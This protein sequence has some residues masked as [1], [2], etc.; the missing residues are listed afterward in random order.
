MRHVPTATVDVPAVGLSLPVQVADVVDGLALALAPRLRGRVLDLGT[1]SGREVL[2][3]AIHGSLDAGHFDTIVSVC[4]LVHV[5]DLFAA[6]TAIEALL[7]PSGS[8]LVVE[9]VDRPVPGG[10]VLAT[11]GAL[12][13]R[14]RG[15]QV[16][17]DVP[18]TIRCTSLTVVDIERIAMP[19]PIWPLRSFVA[20][21][22][23]RVAA[24]STD[25]A[26]AR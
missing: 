25:A 7:A 4:G 17:R 3:A 12:H 11:L 22:A 9:P 13:Q 1:A 19:T 15:V 14:V 6:V 20:L 24:P 5:P 2:I 21:T 10:L 23:A 16:N 8:A 26:G 18:A